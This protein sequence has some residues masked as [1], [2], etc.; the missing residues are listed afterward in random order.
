MN[1]YNWFFTKK[2]IP[3]YAYH[4]DFY[5]QGLSIREK[6]VINLFFTKLVL[7]RWTQTKYIR[8]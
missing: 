1:K 8:E 3:D 5:D 6:R 4:Y 7:I 2:D